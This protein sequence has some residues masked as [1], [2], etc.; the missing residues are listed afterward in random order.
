MKPQTMRHY[1][2]NFVI[3]FT[4]QQRMTASDSLTH[5]RTHSV[6]EGINLEGPAS[7]EA[8]RWHLTFKNQVQY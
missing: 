2:A 5:T 8:S 3:K 4:L 1:T 6:I 7:L